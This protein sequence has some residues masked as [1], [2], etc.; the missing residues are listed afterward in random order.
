VSGETLG[1]TLTEPRSIVGD[2]VSGQQQLPFKFQILYNFNGPDFKS[3]SLQNFVESLSN[4]VTFPVLTLVDFEIE[5]S[6][7]LG[8]YF[9]FGF[10]DQSEG[11]DSSNILLASQRVQAF[12]NL[13]TVGQTSKH[14]F[15]VLSGASPQIVPVPSN[16]RTLNFGFTAQARG[17]L[18]GGTL[19]ITMLAKAGGQIRFK[20]TMGQV[21]SKWADIVPKQLTHKAP[22]TAS[23]LSE[24]EIKY[25]QSQRES[26]QRRKEAEG[27]KGGKQPDKV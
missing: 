9:A 6:L 17:E 16:G 2:Q 11:I 12:G 10:W 22:M 23:D 1:Q 13:T 24:D 7:G 18:G 14:V 3:Y 19:I 27:S 25:I 21:A 15:T 8:Q 20:S 4:G 26:R 5:Y